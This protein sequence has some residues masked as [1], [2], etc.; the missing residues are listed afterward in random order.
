[1]REFCNESMPLGPR[2]LLVQGRPC[3]E[4]ANAPLMFLLYP[5]LVHSSTPLAKFTSTSCPERG[6]KRWSMVDFAFCGES[7]LLGGC[8]SACE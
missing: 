2:F 8:W 3:E 7:M 6:Q 5:E 4:Q 1:M